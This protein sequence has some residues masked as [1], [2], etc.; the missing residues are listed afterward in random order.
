VSTASE[1][2]LGATVKGRGPA[3]Y[4]GWALLL[5]LAVVLLLA[6]EIFSPFDL[7]QI[8]TQAL[9][10]GIAA[11]SLTFLQRYGGMTSLG[12]V[13]IYGIAGFAMGNVVH[14]INSEGGLN[15]GWNPWLGVL[16]GIFVAMLVAFLFGAIASRS[17]GIYF[18]MITLALALLVF[19]FFGQVTTLS[20]FGGIR[21]VSHPGYLNDPV[22]HPNPLYYTCLGCS[23]FV[24]LLLRYLVRT[25]FGLALQ[26]IRDDPPRMRSLGYNVP[27]H[28]ALAFMLGAFVAGIAGIL[29]VWF[30]TQISPGSI[31][32]T[33]TIAVLII[34]VIGGLSRLEGAWIGALAYSLIDYYARQDTPTLGLWLNPGR[35]ATIIGLVFLL[36]VL[37]SPD[38]LIGIGAKVSRF[39][40][41]RLG[42]SQTSSAF[43][44][45]EGGD[46]QAQPASPAGA[47][48]A[49]ASESPSSGVQ[50]A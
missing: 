22:T 14:T 48:A 43:T 6:P 41:A 19:Y 36:I 49:A 30:N 39:I 42:R 44:P 4:L 31:N 1:G 27:L 3:A 50:E 15:L 20:G 26:G 21:S 16:F 12:Q 2:R 9:W 38:G 40:V 5:A 23:V 46:G 24:Y 13:A 18:L 33:Q 35:F 34:A 45:G 37:L 28:R 17:Y 8:L 29:S 7:S 11:A 25:P 10:L 47:G 32:V